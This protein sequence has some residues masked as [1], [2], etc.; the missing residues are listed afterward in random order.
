[1]EIH[2]SLTDVSIVNNHCTV[3]HVPIFLHT[4]ITPFSNPI[5]FLRVHSFGMIKGINE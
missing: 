3:V 1:M 2:T 4:E 5:G